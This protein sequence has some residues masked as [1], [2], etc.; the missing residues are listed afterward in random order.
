MALSVPIINVNIILSCCSAAR[1]CK[2]RSAGLCAV[3][4]VINF[5]D[6]PLYIHCA[7]FKEGNIYLREELKT[8]I[9]EAFLCEEFLKHSPTPAHLMQQ[10]DLTLILPL[11]RK[12]NPRNWVMEKALKAWHPLLSRQTPGATDTPAFLTKSNA[13]RAP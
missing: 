2:L 12:P 9:S 4:S 11:V 5:D 10:P 1:C 7:T 13:R 8:S 6:S 3:I